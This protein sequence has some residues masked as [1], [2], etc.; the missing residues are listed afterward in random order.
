MCILDALLRKGRDLSQAHL[1][2][3]PLYERHLN[4]T[5]SYAWKGITDL[6][7]T[8]IRPSSLTE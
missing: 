6:Q 8:Q 1:A 3:K 2:Y 5:M 7:Q 4:V